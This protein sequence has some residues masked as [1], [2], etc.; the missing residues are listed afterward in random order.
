MHITR[1]KLKPIM[2]TVLLIVLIIFTLSGLT[3]KFLR[4]VGLKHLHQHNQEYLQSSLNQS[5]AT[6]AVLSGIKVGLAVIEGSELGVGFGIEVG[7][8]VQSTYDYVDVAWRTVLSA[9]AILMGTRF[10]LHASQ[11]LESWFLSATLILALLARLLFLT[12][13]KWQRLLRTLRD[14][15]VFSAILTV[16]L[17]LILPLSVWG[18]SR[19]SNAITAP[20]LEEADADLTTIRGEL[21]PDSGEGRSGIIGILQGARDKLSQIMEFIIAK[22]RNLSLLVLKIIAGYLFDTI[23]FPLTLFLLF[24]HLTRIVA[25]YVFDIQRQKSFHDDLEILIAKY[26]R[27]EKHGP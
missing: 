20:A 19:L 11:L 8:A 15:T 7:D 2:A 23:I 9:S 14:L 12:V 22:T 1:P 25:K 5:L 27:P 17:Y 26:I 24:F 18:G 21:F 3:Q 10:L 13:P 16:A 6:F 4:E